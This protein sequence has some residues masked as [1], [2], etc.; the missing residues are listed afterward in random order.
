MLLYSMLLCKKIARAPWGHKKFKLTKL[1]GGGNRIDPKEK[2]TQRFIQA[3]SEI[4]SIVSSS[5]N[6][7]KNY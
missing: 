7:N 2:Y 6:D 1:G 4:D 5:C 3:Y